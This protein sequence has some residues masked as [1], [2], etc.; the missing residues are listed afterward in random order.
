MAV[1]SGQRLV[2]PATGLG[3]PG[4]RRSTVAPAATLRTTPPI[5]APSSASGHAKPSGRV[6]TISAGAWPPAFS[7][8]GAR[9]GL[10]RAVWGPTAAAARAVATVRLARVRL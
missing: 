10:A 1:R 2:A 7:P 4:R 9:A 8:D 5:P 6:T 3:V